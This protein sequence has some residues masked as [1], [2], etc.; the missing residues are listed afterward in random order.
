MKNLY[1]RSEYKNQWY[2]DDESEDEIITYLDRKE[3]THDCMRAYPG[4][5][6]AGSSFTFDEMDNIPEIGRIELYIA[7]ALYE[8]EHGELEEW[9]EAYMIHNVYRYK[10]GDFKG[11]IPD[12]D[13][14]AEDIRKI[15]SFM[16]LRFED[17]AIFDPADG[18]V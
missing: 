8:L 14:F 2:I 10:R 18:V 5:L 17:L 3:Y 13:L 7:C 15:E 4:N 16:K 12:E 6:K 11:M 9:L 1:D